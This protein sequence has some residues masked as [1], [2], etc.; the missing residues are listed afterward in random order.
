MATAELKAVITAEDRA[1]PKLRSFGAEVGK[2]AV[3]VG[4]GTIAVNGLRAGFK[5]LTNEAT[6]SIKAFQEQENALAQLDAVL[7]ST[8]GAA[9]L[10]R[11]ELEDMATQL[12]KQTTFADE[13]INKG[14]AMLL[15][16]TK[17]GKEIF[18]QATETILNM[19]QALGQD[20]QSSAIQL[21]KALND[22]IQGVTALRRVG[23]SFNDQQQE[24]IKNLVEQGNLM[25]AQ[26]LILQEL[27]VEFGGSATAAAQ[28]Y[29][30]RMLQL[31]NSIGDMKEKIGEAILKGI[32]PFVQKIVAFVNS[33][34][35]QN[36]ANKITE[37][38]TQFFNFIQKNQAFIM[39]FFQGL[40]WV[41]SVSAKQ[42]AWVIDLFTKL[43]TAIGNALF[44]IGEFAN[45][46]RNT[47]I[48]GSIFGKLA[49]FLGFADGGT[50]T[51]NKPMIVGERGPEL[52][53]PRSGGMV[54]PNDKLGGMGS[55][56]INFHGGVSLA[57][58]LDVEQFA[59]MLGR[60]VALARNG[61]V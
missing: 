28:T 29:Q 36:F 2:I 15:T 14:Q 7:K 39:G 34:E 4:L 47:P 45:K 51:G 16:F 23:V 49:G 1:S 54:I 48:I 18:P 59:A 43:S 60:Q 40:G 38:I 55:V 26:K 58:N 33:P 50:F 46:A 37:S 61:G 13:A 56:E 9:G 30:G 8:G 32:E 44:K 42:L 10:T 25:A 20:L 41:I 27:A 6:S 35:G 52:M 31:N 22:P 17:I 57:S 53:V 12:Q 3:G 11:K 24:T 5:F 21:G 19:S